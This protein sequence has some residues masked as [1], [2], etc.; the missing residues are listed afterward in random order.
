MRSASHSLHFLSVCTLWLIS[1][2]TDT[3]IPAKK[4]EKTPKAFQLV[5]TA[6]QLRLMFPPVHLRTKTLPSC[7]IC[8]MFIMTIGAS[9]TEWTGTSQRF[10]MIKW[11]AILA[12]W[13]GKLALSFEPGYRI[14]EM[15]YSPFVLTCTVSILKTYPHF[16][17]YMLFL[18]PR[19]ISQHC[20]C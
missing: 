6:C 3:Q 14:C 19:F 8:V 17:N 10:P 7:F 12:T 20:H 15:D 5:S 9:N 11:R 16:L 2:S 18:L 1:Q 4:K 13:P